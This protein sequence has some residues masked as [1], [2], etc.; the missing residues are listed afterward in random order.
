[1]KKTNTPLYSPVVL[2][3]LFTLIRLWLLI[4][5]LLYGNQM[6]NNNDINSILDSLLFTQQNNYQYKDSMQKT[7]SFE[8][9]EETPY[10]DSSGFPT[11]GIGNLLEKKSYKKLPDKYSNM[12]VSKVDAVNNFISNYS[13]IQEVLKKKY[14]KG[15]DELPEK[16]RGVLNDLAFNLG[17]FKLFDEFPGF[18]EDFKKGKYSE[19]AKE[20]KFTNPDEGNMNFSDWWKQIGALNTESKNLKRSDNR[21]T[22]AYDILL[23][24][25]G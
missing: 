18:I 22:S 21:G 17:G 14:G 8:N 24:L 9:Y 5:I 16:A 20:L 3:T 11:I 2:T 1:M 6:A 7:M 15:Y 12:K 19:A 23:Q 4:P 10:L 13:E 25:G